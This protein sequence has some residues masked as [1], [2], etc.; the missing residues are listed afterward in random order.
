MAF[1]PGKKRYDDNFEQVTGDVPSAF[2]AIANKPGG[3]E[4]GLPE[5]SGGL[6][7]LDHRLLSGTPAECERR[8]P[9]ARRRQEEAQRK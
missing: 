3:A 2:G 6:A 4:G 1:R 8:A 5:L 9:I 7:L